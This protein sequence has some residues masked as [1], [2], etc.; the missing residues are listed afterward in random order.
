MLGVL[1]MN[2]TTSET[3]IGTAD[4]PSSFHA[5]DKD[6]TPSRIWDVTPFWPAVVL[7]P[8]LVLGLA[9]LAGRGPRLLRRN[10]VVAGLLTGGALLGLA[11]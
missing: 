5:G 10:P 1:T 6:D 9:G 4:R 8:A 2:V 3:S 7:T 11:K